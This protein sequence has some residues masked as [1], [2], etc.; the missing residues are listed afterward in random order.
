MHWFG[1]GGGAPTWSAQTDTLMI[2]YHRWQSLEAFA[3]FMNLTSSSPTTKIWCKLL[4]SKR[5]VRCLL[6]AHFEKNRIVQL[7]V[8]ISYCL[9]LTFTPRSAELSHL[10]SGTT[11]CQQHMHEMIGAKEFIEFADAWARALNYAQITLL[12]AAR[13]S[14][15]RVHLSYLKFFEKNSTFYESYGYYPCPQSQFHYHLLTDLLETLGECPLINVPKLLASPLYESWSDLMNFFD[16]HSH[17][18]Q[19]LIPFLDPFTP[20][21]HVYVILVKEAAGNCTGNVEDE[22]HYDPD[23]EIEFEDDEDEDDTDGISDRKLDRIYF[24]E[25]CRMITALDKFVTDFLEYHLQLKKI[26]IEQLIQMCKSLDPKDNDFA[27]NRAELLDGY[28]VSF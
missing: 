16:E 13:V 17:K 22:E 25:Y 7:Q 4:P 11:E 24:I 8:S 10:M 2:Q 15:D 3:Q 20:F 12:D 14:G 21:G 9:I 27:R 18:L 5:Q 1:I 26:D 28:K 19:K 23:E 6:E